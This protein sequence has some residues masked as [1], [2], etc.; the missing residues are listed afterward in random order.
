MPAHILTQKSLQSALQAAKQLAAKRST[1]IKIADGEGL[2][3]VV[4]PDGGASW[5]HRYSL[6]GQK[7]ETSIGAYPAI[8]LALARELH[9]EQRE[10]I[11]KGISPVAEKQAA[12]AALQA[13]RAKLQQQK[14][15]VLQLMEDWVERKTG[16]PVHKDDIRKAFKKDVLPAIGTLPPATVSRDAIMAIL[17]KIESRGSTDM[18]R[19]VRMWLRQMFDFA[20]EDET[21]KLTNQPVPAG[22]LRTFAA[23]T[24]E[25]FPAITEVAEVGPLMQA[26][27]SFPHPVTRTAL[28]LQAHTF[29][30]PAMIR[31]ATWDEFDLDAGKWVLR[32]RTGMKTAGNANKKEHWVP[33]SRQVVELLRK[34]QGVVGD[35]GML[36]PGMRPGKCISDGTMNAA[37]AT[38]GYH[39]KHTPHGFRATAMTIL[40]ERLG[41]HDRNEVIDK[42]LLHEKKTKVQRAYDRAQYWEQRKTMAQE[43]SDWLSAQTG[44]Q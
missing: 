39:G 15:S 42:H 30:R 38:L 4:R 29:Q 41:W 11:A 37:L 40:K 6:L 44:E 1:R 22:M 3:L 43:W 14:D 28:L 2:T 19:R 7:S 27:G 10:K 16:G 8:S 32:S 20:A 23:H 24:P 35:E 36:F 34:Y 17:R 9:A 33:L 13:E 18:V 26:I 21:R 12:K 25:S 5:I 31:G